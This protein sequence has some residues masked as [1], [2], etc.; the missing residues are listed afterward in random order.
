[1][2]HTETVEA[3]TLALIK[4]L[5][6]DPVLKDFVLVGGTALSLQLG[7]RKSIDIDL[8]SSDAFDAKALG[9]HLDTQY[10][11]ERI[12]ALTNG[13]FSLLDQIKVDMIAHQYP[14]IDGIKEAEGIRMASPKEIGA[15][16][17]HAIVHSGRRLKDYV[18][19]HFLLERHSL[20]EL[21]TAYSEK[22]PG[23]NAAM[24][25]NALLYHE[26][27]DF[28]TGVDLMRRNFNWS[29]IAE[30]LRQAVVDPKKI[31][32]GIKFGEVVGRKNEIDISKHRK[33][34]RR[35]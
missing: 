16:K 5:S 31:F 6:G 33:R 14:W 18:D 35:I 32:Q 17:L 34:G 10:K 15:M 8:F 13:V 11:G 24:A 2:L 3:G 25:K 9:K 30:R 23:Y 26:D 29:E 21:T 27:I 19:M 4:R 20:D 22:H 7:H 28:Q 1:M 12:Q